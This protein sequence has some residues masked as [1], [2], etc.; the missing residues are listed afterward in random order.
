VDYL[1]DNLGAARGRMPD[2]AMRKRIEALY[3]AL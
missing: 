2:A 1:T 3:D